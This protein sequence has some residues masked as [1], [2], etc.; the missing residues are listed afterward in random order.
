V[1][2]GQATLPRHGGSEN[3]I[4]LVFQECYWPSNPRGEAIIN[5]VLADL[6]RSMFH[7]DAVEQVTRLDIFG[8][9]IGYRCP[10]PQDMIGWLTMQPR[11]VKTVRKAYLATNLHGGFLRGYAVRGQGPAAQVSLF[12]IK[13]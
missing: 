8:A 10:G 1:Q 2:T 3:V 12:V 9:R 7:G 13:D 6:W 11:I 4:G 5:V